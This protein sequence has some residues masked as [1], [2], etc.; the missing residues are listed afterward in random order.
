[1]TQQRKVGAALPDFTEGGEKP[2]KILSA[3]FKRTF[4]TASNFFFFFGKYEFHKGFCGCSNLEP[5]LTLEP[6]RGI[7]SVS[8]EDPYKYFKR[9]RSNIHFSP[10]FLLCSSDS[11]RCCLRI[12]SL[13]SRSLPAAYPTDLRVVCR[14][15]ILTSCARFCVCVC[16]CEDRLR[17]VTQCAGVEQER[18]PGSR[19]GQVGTAPLGTNASSLHFLF[20][21]MQQKRK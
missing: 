21:A 20:V 18:Q 15:G 1:M 10:Q 19:G 13:N 14:W 7:G 16:V 9:G 5:Q 17:L 6:L 12:G 4:F 11:F 3:H 8:E 2:G